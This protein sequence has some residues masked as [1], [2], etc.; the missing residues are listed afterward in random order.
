MLEFVD[1]GQYELKE[2]YNVF[3][4]ATRFD[5]FMN[6]KIESLIERFKKGIKKGLPNYKHISDLGFYMTIHQD[7]EYKDEMQEIVNYCVYLNQGLKEKTEK[8]DKNELVELFK[9]DCTKFFEKV[10]EPESPYH[11]RPFW[12]NFDP[13]LVH[14]KIVSLSNKEIWDISHYFGSRY[15]QRVAYELRVEKPFVEELIALLNKPK[16]RENNNLKNA[17]LDILVRRLKNSL[18]HFVE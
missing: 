12:L 17:A 5:N 1:H 4:F 6:Y 16:N 13:K 11:Y 10:S 15:Y 18:T 9:S 3:H 2:Y 8:R 7:A 14:R